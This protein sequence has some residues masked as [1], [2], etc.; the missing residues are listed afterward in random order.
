MTR[1]SGLTGVTNRSSRQSL[2][3]VTVTSLAVILAVAATWALWPL[4][5]WVG[6]GLLHWSHVSVPPGLQIVVLVFYV[7]LTFATLVPCTLF[8]AWMSIGRERRWR[9]TR[10]PMVS[11]IIPAFNEEGAIRRCLRAATR[12]DYPIYETLVVDD[13]SSDRTSSL[14]E[15]EDVTCVR[16]RRQRGKVNAV[17]IAAS[18]AKGEI[19]VFTDGDSWL[20]PGAL[21][22]LVVRFADPQVGAV[23]GTVLVAEPR[24]LLECWQQLEYLHGQAVVKTAQLNS[25]GSVIVCPGVV[26]AI[27]ASLL[28]DI[29]GFSARTVT[30]D[31]DLTLELIARGHRVEYEARAIGYTTTPQTWSELHRQRRR[32]FRGTLQV[33]KL[34]RALIFD[35]PPSAIGRFWLPYAAVFGYAAPAVT[36][37]ALLLAPLLAAFT[38][39]FWEAL[40]WGALFW[41]MLELSQLAQLVVAVR[42][43]R[44]P[45]RLLLA[46]PLFVPYRLFLD[47]I[48]IRVMID[49]R[50]KTPARWT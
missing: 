1:S 16:V 43:S 3:L 33:L 11:V 4:V 23:A 32:W 19:L 47:L 8:L 20:E 12:L 6:A 5:D 38:G 34:H 10:L 9:P 46:A 35:R 41:A 27:R 36:L 22:H 39:S 44:Q 13:G 30:E 2:R 37:A 26:F 42:V 21:R 15:M 25:S 28:A 18:R 40:R 49:E 48:R 7:V 31:F 45:L 24:S 50:H 17:N 29:G 14:I